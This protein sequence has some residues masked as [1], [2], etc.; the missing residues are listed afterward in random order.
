MAKGFFTQGVSLLT[1][2]QVTMDGLKSALRQAGFE[3]V[4]ESPAQENWA[5]GGATLIV[6][7]LPEVNGYVAVDVVNQPWPDSM[8]DPESDSTIFAAWS[9]GHFGPFAFP[10]SLARA[11]EHAWAWP[12]AQT[13][14]KGHEGF[15][16]LRMSYIFGA[17]KDL[18]VMPAEYDPIAEMMFLSQVALALLK[19]PGV[20][21]YFNPNGEVLRDD[22]SFRE[23]WEPCTEQQNLP[24][25]LWAN[26]RFFNLSETLGF[27]ETVGNAQFEIRDV[28]AVFPFAD[29][30]PDDVDYYL[31]NVTHYL[32]GLEREMKSGEAIDGPGESN[33]SWTMEVLDQGMMDPPRRVLRLYPKSSAK[34][35]QK[36]L[37]TVG[38]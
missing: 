35:V 22:A 19:A 15:I 16:R 37:S 28:E 31:R 8:G 6:P 10:G 7:F 21:C 12:P 24:L 27:M 36:A 33:L 32:L 4:K 29:Y 9:M 20:K 17:R 1:D 3:I 38:R 25:S 11:Q 26:I 23:V 18:P 5:F 14:S 34:A 30:D 13:I 2:G